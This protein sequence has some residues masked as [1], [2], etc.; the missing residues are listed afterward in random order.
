MIEEEHKRDK[1]RRAE[2]AEANPP[3]RHSVVQAEAWIAALERLY[4]LYEQKAAADT[5]HTISL[6]K[7]LEDWR[8]W[9][10]EDAAGVAHLF[11]L[12]RNFVLQPYFKSGEIKGF[13]GDVLAFGEQL[14]TSHSALVAILYRHYKAALN[15]LLLQRHLASKTNP[16]L[17]RRGWTIADYEMKLHDNKNVYDTLVKKEAELAEQGAKLRSV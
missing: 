7:K 12:F 10:R 6:A 4:I 3:P 14:H 13:R 8:N 15:L 17:A 9:E 11:G 16:S 5:A 1:E 2:E